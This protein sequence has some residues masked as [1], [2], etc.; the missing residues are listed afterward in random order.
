MAQDCKVGILGAGPAGCCAAYFLQNECDVKVIDYASPLRTILPTG[1]GRCN[2]AHAEYDFRLLAE[3]YPRGKKFLYSIFSKFSTADAQELF[4][5]IGIETYIQEDYRIFPISNSSKEVRDTFLNNMKKVTFKKEKGLR[6]EPL[7]SGI[8]LITDMDSYI[9]DY[10][11]IATGGHASYDLLQRIGIKIIPPKPALVGLVTEENLKSAA[12]VSLSGVSA[13][14]LVGDVLFT[15][16]GISGPLVYK[17]S[18]LRAREN[19]PYNLSFDFY[20]QE[21]NMQDMLNNNPHKTILNLLSEFFPKKVVALIL[22][23]ANIDF[24]TKCHKINSIQRDS[25]L[26][27]MHNFAVKIVGV[28]KDGEVVTAGGVCLDNVN[29]KTMESKNVSGL[30]FVGEV[31]DIDGFCGGFNLQNCWST[32]YVAANAILNSSK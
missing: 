16:N 28:R 9:F 22:N 10:L 2:L 1:G 31:L 15:H 19:F 21:F 23:R 5:K 6:I 8:K 32:A 30:Y 26:D 7:T 20:P 12:G 29:S 4:E 13:D 27:I 17:I 18:S 25:I 24:D 3:N 14:G 11:I